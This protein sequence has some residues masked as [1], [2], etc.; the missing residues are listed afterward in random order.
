[1]AMRNKP[2][3]GAASEPRK[4]STA[5]PDAPARAPLR[6]ARRSR[7]KSVFEPAGSWVISDDTR[8]ALEHCELF[9]DF[10][11]DQLMQVAALVEER[12][13][14]PDEKLLIEGAPASHVMVVVDGQAVAQIKLNAGAGYHSGS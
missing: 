7:R 9:L 10:S 4:T 3:K 14:R 12:A 6:G 2:G 8:S 5:V 11:R 13:L 1:M